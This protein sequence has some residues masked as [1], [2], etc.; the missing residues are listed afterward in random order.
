MKNI[1]L[2]SF[3]MLTLGSCSIENDIVNN[4]TV[5]LPIEGVDIPEEFKFGEVFPI[6]VT[7]FR[8]S[9][10]HLF[11]TFYFEKNENETTVI[12]VNTVYDDTDCEIYDVNAN[13]TLA[14][15]NFQVNDTDTQV[16]KFWQ[17]KDDSGSD[18]YL[19]VEVPVV[20]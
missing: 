12:L 10:C 13:E 15:F 2:L 1:F 4:V 18:L 16:F 19:V 7:Y 20:E 3:L 11:N 9:S 17:G 8:P 5:T 6:D 14:S